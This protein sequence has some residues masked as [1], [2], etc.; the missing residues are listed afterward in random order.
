MTAVTSGGIGNAAKIADPQSVEES[1]C[2]RRKTKSRSFE[3]LW[4]EFNWLRGEDLNLRP[5]GY[6]IHKQRIFNELRCD[7]MAW[8]AMIKLSTVRPLRPVH[9][10]DQ[11]RSFRYPP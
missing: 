11:R 1:W 9:T 10:P 7:E 8:R 3:R 4:I 6:E 2:E 5:L